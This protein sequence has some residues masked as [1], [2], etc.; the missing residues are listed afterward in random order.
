M[1]KKPVLLISFHNQ[2][3]LG[4]RYLERALQRAGHE[5][6]ILFFKGFNSVKPQP[7]TEK[8]LALLKETVE[9]TGPCLIGLSVMSSL[10]LD[11]VYKVHRT[12]REN[13]TI[14]ILW[15]GVYATLFPD[16]SLKY[17]DYV[18]RGEGEDAIVELTDALNNGESVD[19]IPN[20]SYLKD[21]APM[22][23]D[24]RPLREDLDFYGYP[25]IGGNN[26]YLIHQDALYQ[27]DPQLKSVSYELTAS[28]GCPFVCSYC[29][30]VN[31]RR[32][33]KDKGTFVR[34][35]SADNVMAE[36]LEAKKKIRGLKVIHFWDEIFPDDDAWIDEFTTRYKNE[37]SLP[38]EIWG[39]PLKVTKDLIRKMVDAGLFKVVMGIQSGSP[40]IRKEIFHRVETQE[41]IIRA[42]KILHECRVPQIIYDFM[43]LHPFETEEDLKQTYE[44]CMQLSWPFELQLHGLNFLPGTDIV[45]RAIQDGIMSREELDQLMHNSTMQQQYDM[46]WGRKSQSDMSNFWYSLI[47]MSQFSI[48][49]PVARLLAAR[50]NSSLLVR[51]G[52]KGKDFLQPIAKSRYY[53][54]KGRLVLKGLI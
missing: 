8:E 2:K 4:V 30:S 50:H 3:A 6:Y 41:E 19:S 17:A 10:Y 43:L 9:K 52:L 27:G 16:R 37:I 24:V 14:P 39:H 44:L 26:K 47:Y 53:Y 34:F 28:R 18:L 54:K 22:V 21:G 23:N 15:G 33:Y 12:L 20:L 11:T 46:H 51:C 25:S 36:L 29:S 1:A 5:V 38:F 31:L 45:E 13:F 48:G 32:V 42:S 40:R 49:R 35:R 7:A